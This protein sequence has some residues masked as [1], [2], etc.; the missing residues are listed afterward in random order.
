MGSKCFF[1]HM[2]L[3][4]GIIYYIHFC[5][6]GSILWE[7]ICILLHDASNA[8]FNH[9]VPHHRKSFSE[10]Q[11]V[12]LRNKSGHVWWK[13]AMTQPFSKVMISYDLY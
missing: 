13:Q 12:F 11:E 5:D 9:A 3:C 1:Y 10:K 7:T 8:L 2:V 4:D 6:A